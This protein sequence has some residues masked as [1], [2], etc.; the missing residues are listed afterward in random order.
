ML[1]Q[2]VARRLRPSSRRRASEAH[3]HADSAVHLAL[4][5]LAHALAPSTEEAAAVGVFE[6]QRYLALEATRLTGVAEREEHTQQFVAL[7]LES[8]DGVF[9]GTQ[10]A[11]AVVVGWFQEIRTGSFDRREKVKRER[12]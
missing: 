1:V 8:C 3:A 2:A 12:E 5:R 7:L 6:S 11:L 9:V 10:E 4:L